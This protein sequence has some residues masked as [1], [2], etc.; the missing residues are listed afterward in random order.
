MCKG[1]WTFG[2]CAFIVVERLDTLQYAP[3]VKTGKLTEGVHYHGGH[4]HGCNFMG[5]IITGAIITG[6]INTGP[7]IAGSLSQGAGSHR[8]DRW[9]TLGSI[10]V[11]QMARLLT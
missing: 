2:K 8:G 11:S 7:I 10:R 4:Y 6:A 5:V 1:F 9:I 3:S